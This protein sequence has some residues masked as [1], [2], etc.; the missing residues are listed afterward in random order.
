MNKS[1]DLVPG[2]RNTFTIYGKVLNVGATTAENCRLMVDFYDNMTLLQTSEIEIGM[3]KVDYWSDVIVREVV[4]VDS[5]DS[6][7]KIE[8][9]P[10]W[11]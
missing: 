7:T 8:V 9:T 10:K 11:S 6:V 5:A 1:F 3:G 2:S 4:R